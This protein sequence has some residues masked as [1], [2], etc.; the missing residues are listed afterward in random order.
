MKTVLLTRTKENN[1]Y[2][3]KYL[4]NKSYNVLQEPMLENSINSGC[5]DG[6]DLKNKKIL[7]TSNFLAK[8]LKH[9]IKNPEDVFIYV[10]GENSKK[11]LENNKFNILACSENISGII[12]K[13]NNK[14]VLYL[15]GNYISQI[16]PFKHEE[17]I[18][19]TTKYKNSFSLALIQQ[20]KLHKIDI[21]S[22][23]SK[24]TANS[25]ISA[26]TSENLGDYLKE[27]KFICFSKEIAEIFKKMGFISLYSE[28]PDIN[29][30]IKQF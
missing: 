25:I 27:T 24:E 19:Y 17:I 14:P 21:I 10:V 23:F 30:Y 20:I 18:A 12:D 22:V 1:E 11:I 2:L 29:S 13:I 26:I 9:L 4:I 16:L 15:R 7:V 8:S 3:R 5:L 28:K 6:V